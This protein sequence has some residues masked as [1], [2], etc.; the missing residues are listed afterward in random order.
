LAIAADALFLI[1]FLFVIPQGSAVVFVLASIFCRHSDLSL[2]KAKNP[3]ISLFAVACSSFTRRRHRH[4]NQSA[5]ARHVISPKRIRKA[6]S[7]H[8]AHRQGIVISA[9]AHSQGIVIHQ[10]ASARHVISTEAQRVEKSASLPKPIRSHGRAVVVVCSL[11]TSSSVSNIAPN[12]F[13]T[14]YLR[15]AR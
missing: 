5:S 13:F 2:S 11:R 6:S 15:T 14:P 3:R 9:K 4:L 7:F 10:S 12:P 1:A 8:K